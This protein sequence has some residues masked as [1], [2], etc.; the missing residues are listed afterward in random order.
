METSLPSVSTKE[1]FTAG[2]VQGVI[3]S[4]PNMNSPTK[5]SSRTPLSSSPGRL[6][7]HGD[8]MSDGETGEFSLSKILI[9]EGTPSEASNKRR[10]LNNRL[11][12]EYFCFGAQGLYVEKPV[13]RRHSD[14]VYK[15]S[16]LSV[17]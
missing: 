17:A 4:V 9:D 7:K 16:A 12:N 5:T 10:S 6:N 14:N 13:P 1:K 2:L 3:Q 15:Q 11:M 8:S